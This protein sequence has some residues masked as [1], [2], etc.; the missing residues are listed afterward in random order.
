MSFADVVQRDGFFQFVIIVLSAS[1]AIKM[2]KRKSAFIL[3][4]N[5]NFVLE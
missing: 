1:E 4:Y 5:V 3:T 2:R